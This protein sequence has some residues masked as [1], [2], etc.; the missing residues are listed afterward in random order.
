MLKTALRYL[1]AGWSVFPVEPRGKKAI[2]RWETF[3]S[4]RANKRLITYWWTRWPNAN[5][6]IATGEISGF[7][8]LD[9]DGFDQIAEMK[10]RGLPQTRAVNTGKGAHFYFK[11]PDF[12]IRNRA[13]IFPHI[14]IRGTGGYVVAPPSVHPSGRVYHWACS[15]PIVDAPD[16]L[17]ELLKPVP[18]Q[19]V[20]RPVA[21]GVG[22]GERALNEELAR[23]A[24]A[25][26]SMRN[27]TLNIA[28]FKL[29]RV[30]GAGRLTRAEVEDALLPVAMSI[31]LSERESRATIAS[32][33][34]AGISKPRGAQ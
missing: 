33:L 31:G 17:L 29:G 20:A 7:F 19:P 25:Q 32:G 28:A 30:V 10:R 3:Q 24:A 2:G 6:G 18:I 26:L 4:E 5:I 9:C 21:V 27:D 34:D 14:D 11:C 8:A 22:Y 23:V 16:W 12:P 1:A 13:G 15:D